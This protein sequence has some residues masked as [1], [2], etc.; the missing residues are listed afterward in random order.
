MASST[1]G[2]IELLSE[3][4]ETA[5]IGR[6]RD[7][8]ESALTELFVEHRTRLKRMVELRLDRRLRGRVDASDVLQDSFVDLAQQLEGYAKN[9]KMPFFLWLRRITGQRLSKTHRAHLQTD[10]RDASLEV[11]IY[12]GGMPGASSF[13]LASKLVGQFTSVGNR[14]IRAEVQQKLQDVLN[15]MDENDREILAMRHIEQL[16]N[17]E[18]ATL[19][20]LTQSAATHRYYRALR[21]LRATLEQIP[22]IFDES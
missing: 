22:G 9:P 21:R 16:S 4:Q 15:D 18:I 7:G 12:Q 5:L 17:S 2:T 3:E 8:D 14:A 10:K 1:T 13:F 6:A 11:S 20:E 19:L